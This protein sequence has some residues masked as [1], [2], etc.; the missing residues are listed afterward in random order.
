M[1]IIGKFEKFF[2]ITKCLDSGFG[3]IQMKIILQNKSI[4]SSLKFV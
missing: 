3:W 1:R 4:K 2:Q